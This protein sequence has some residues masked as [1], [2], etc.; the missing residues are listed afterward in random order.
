MLLRRLSYL[1]VETVE[2]LTLAAVLGS[3]F[4]VAQ[5][6]LV[7][8]R[9]VVELMRVLDEALRA[10]ILAECG[11]RLT[12][13]HDLIREALYSDVALPIRTGLHLEVGRALAQAG[14][15][16]IQVAEHLALGAPPGD[17]DA[18]SWLH[19]AA[20]AEQSRSGGGCRAAHPGPGDRRTAP[21]RDRRPFG[22]SRAGARV[23]WATC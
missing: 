18:V 3:T 22:G 2:V 8:R 23:V 9:P 10:G 14:A 20:R 5:L 16:A 17:T 13:R 11:T 21:S 19:E 12:F 7:T 6:A 4:D 15:P 1:P